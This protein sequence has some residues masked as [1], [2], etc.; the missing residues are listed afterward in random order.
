MENY[1]TG[2]TL[3]RSTNDFY[4][5]GNKVFNLKGKKNSIYSS[6]TLIALMYFVKGIETVN[7]GR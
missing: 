3:K 2:I 4:L 5:T 7:G 1:E 6:V